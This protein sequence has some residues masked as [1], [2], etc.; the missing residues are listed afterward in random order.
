LPW[1]QEAHPALFG[2]SVSHTTR[3]PRPGEQDGVHY[4]FTDRD[5]FLAGVAQGACDAVM[6]LVARR[7]RR[8]GVAWRRSATRRITQG[9]RCVARNTR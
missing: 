7:W 6:R 5:A 1:R 3:A 2:F 4:H 8:C 9:L